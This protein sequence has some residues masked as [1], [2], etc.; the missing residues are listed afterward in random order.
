MRLH[1]GD[2][3]AAVGLARGREHGADLDRV[4]AVV[5]DHGDA[6]RGAGTRE[7][8]LDAAEA[9]ERPAQHVVGDRELA[10]HRDRGERVLHVVPAGHGQPQALDAAVDE[11]AH[12]VAQLDVELGAAQIE[13]RHRARARPP[14]G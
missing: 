13:A 6:A 2:H 7:A 9:G 14:A 4:M 8:A 1:D 10:R 5:V 3:A 12:A 11:A